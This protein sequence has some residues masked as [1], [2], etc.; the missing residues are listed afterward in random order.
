[1]TILNINAQYTTD[2]KHIKKF[3]KYN[4][5]PPNMQNIS[6]DIF[7]SKYWRIVSDPSLIEQ[8]LFYPPL[9]IETDGQSFQI[10]S[11]NL[12]FDKTKLSGVVVATDFLSKRL[13]YFSFFNEFCHPTDVE[14]DTGW[15]VSTSSSR[16]ITDYYRCIKYNRQLS[17]EELSD[18]KLWLLKDCPGWTGI[19][20][21]HG[22]D[23]M[24]TF[25]TTN[26]SSG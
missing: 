1:M 10:T 14:S 16:C 12:Y 17:T 8:R 3:G 21:F 24:Y 4:D 18:V 20:C 13:F 15:L 5:I 6:E 23:G 2:E 25:T 7:I 11:A 19:Y 26:D 9:K 22:L